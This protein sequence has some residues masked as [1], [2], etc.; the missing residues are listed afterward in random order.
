MN[1]ALDFS[2]VGLIALSSG[3]FGA[4]FMM[5][6][7]SHNIT[8]IRNAAREVKLERERHEKALKELERATRELEETKEALRETFNQVYHKNIFPEIKRGIGIFNVIDSYADDG[9]RDCG[10]AERPNHYSFIRLV[11]KDLDI[12]KGW[13]DTGREELTRV[14]DRVQSI[15]EKYQHL[16]E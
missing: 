15:M 13:C 7:H 5:K 14:S 1:S 8:T 3:F 11:K 10:F 4:M 9:I 6:R 16:Q 2:I 12:I